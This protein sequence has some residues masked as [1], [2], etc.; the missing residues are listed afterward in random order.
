MSENKTVAAAPGSAQE[1]SLIAPDVTAEDFLSG[2]TGI[3]MGFPRTNQTMVDLWSEGFQLKGPL[4]APSEVG[5]YCQARD[6][7]AKHMWHAILTEYV[8]F[9]AAPAVCAWYDDTLR[10]R[11]EVLIDFAAKAVAL[12]QGKLE[13]PATGFVPL[14]RFLKDQERAV[15]V[16]SY[17][18][19][20]SKS[21]P[22]TFGSLHVT[23]ATSDF[24]CA[25]T[26]EASTVVV[27]FVLNNWQDMELMLGTEVPKILQGW[28]RYRTPIKNRERSR[29]DAVGMVG[30]PIEYAVH[31]TLRS[32][33][34]ICDAAGLNLIQEEQ[35]LSAFNP[36][37]Y[38]GFCE[39]GLQKIWKKLGI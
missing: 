27:K 8:R 13:E 25:V 29:Y 35:Y 7:L 32:N 6:Q 10:A 33:K 22:A 5:R 21:A 18:G 15:V 39:K 23:P 34:D 17:E 20:A 2:R 14:D 19:G 26:G 36:N 31:S 30:S 4:D 37:V 11:R 3:I 1:F 12:R 16:G 28:E 24:V 38:I 9:G